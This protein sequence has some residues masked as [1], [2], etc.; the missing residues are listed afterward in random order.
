MPKKLI[1]LANKDDDNFKFDEQTVHI[2]EE[3]DMKQ[4]F[5]Y[6]DF[7]NRKGCSLT[8]WKAE[9]GYIPVD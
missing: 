9:Y 3:W 5:G 1:S 4:L 8:S 2:I 6:T 7:K